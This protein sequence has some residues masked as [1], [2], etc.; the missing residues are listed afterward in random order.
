MAGGATNLATARLAGSRENTLY[1]RLD[2]SDFR[3]RVTEALSVL[4]ARSA[5]L[6]RAGLALGKGITPGVPAA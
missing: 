4:V 6:R 5:R 2:T 3:R 1:R